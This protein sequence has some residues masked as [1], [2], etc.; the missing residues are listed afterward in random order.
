M[1]IDSCSVTFVAKPDKW[2]LQQECY[3][4]KF[5]SSHFMYFKFNLNKLFFLILLSKFFLLVKSWNI[6]Y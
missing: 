6:C 4:F 3:K 2:L 1:A 5:F